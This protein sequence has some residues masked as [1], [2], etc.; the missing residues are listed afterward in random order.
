M[1][2]QTILFFLLVLS[3]LTFAERPRPQ[4]E[5]LKEKNTEKNYFFTDYETTGLHAVTM[6]ENCDAITGK[7]ADPTAANQ[8]R[9]GV[10]TAEERVSGFNY[11]T[12]NKEKKMYFKYAG[13]YRSHMAL[14]G[15]A[16][17]RGIS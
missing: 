12:G 17:H 9:G 3:V 10:L 1:K 6:I 16:G 4:N 15:P 14:K 13:Q 2:K 7:I 8:Y 11:Y 5:K